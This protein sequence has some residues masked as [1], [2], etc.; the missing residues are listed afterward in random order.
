MQILLYAGLPRC[1]FFFF[2]GAF[3]LGQTGVGSLAVDW[4]SGQL[5]WTN[6][7]LKGIY[8]GTS[9]GS[10][11]GLVLS[12]DTDPTD[13]VV[14]PTERYILV[15]WIHLVAKF[16]SSIGIFVFCSTMFWINKG[17]NLVMTIEK[18]G[19]DG[20]L[21]SSLVVVTAQLPR[22]LTMDVAAQR[23]YWLSDFKKVGGLLLD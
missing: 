5:Y 17:P 16:D 23:L 18:A 13:L 15:Y 12:K 19:M 3:S 14:L 8:T 4:L 7:V 10:A 22:G 21:R 6:S 20:F 11:V 9:D 1:T 2:L